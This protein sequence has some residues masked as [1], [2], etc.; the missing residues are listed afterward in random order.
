MATK[1]IHLVEHNVLRYPRHA[2]VRH[3]MWL[4]NWNNLGVDVYIKMA[5]IGEERVLDILLGNRDIINDVLAKENVDNFYSMIQSG[6]LHTCL[7]TSSREA[8]L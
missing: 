4:K 6:F 7:R 5:C 3:K 8:P 1:L 2:D